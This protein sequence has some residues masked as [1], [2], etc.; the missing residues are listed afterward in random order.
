MW[1]V[2]AILVAFTG[3]TANASPVL[4]DDGTPDSVSV[5]LVGRE[6]HLPE[7]AQA[8]LEWDS[9][10]HVERATQLKASE[11]LDGSGTLG[12]RIW[13]FLAPGWGARIYFADPSVKRF[14]LREVPLAAGLDESGRETIA[15][16]VVTSAQ[17]FVAQR[18]SS[19]ISEIES[20]LR[21]DDVTT[22][23][24]A[25]PPR[26]RGRFV[27]EG[28]VKL[29]TERTTSPIPSWQA[30]VGGFYAVQPLDSAAVYHGPGVLLGA[31]N[32][33]SA[34]NWLIALQGQYQ[35]PITIETV[36]ATLHLRGANFG[37]SAAAER[38]LGRNWNLGGELGLVGAYTSFGLSNVSRSTIEPAP[39]AAHLRP[40][41]QVG[42]R[43]GFHYGALRFT[44][45]LGSE[46]ALARTHYDLG[47][48][49]L[50]TPWLLSPRIALDCTWSSHH[51]MQP[52]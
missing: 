19:S 9:K 44:L 25:K 4:A 29:G 39:D 16:V 36:Q 17:A 31:L 2:S 40:R 18:A 38:I 30:H 8:L 52:K 22:L 14:L 32:Q 13:V 3:V 23:R 43:T 41:V 11:I 26:M 12:L 49:P 50:Y 5:T 51:R 27:L 35:F 6:A 33:G 42:M 1:R 47:E 21:H 34:W 45:R 24:Y 48:H 46:F 28:T 10:L 37:V 15:Q 7:L 20:S